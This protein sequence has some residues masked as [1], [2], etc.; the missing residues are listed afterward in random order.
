LG[1]RL[2]LPGVD[3]CG[4]ALGSWQMDQDLSSET[5]VQPP[6]Y[7]IAGSVERVDHSRTIAFSGAE[8]PWEAFRGNAY[9]HHSVLQAM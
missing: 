8:L 7:Q 6:C 2:W 4:V 3:R 9:W 1:G 5:F